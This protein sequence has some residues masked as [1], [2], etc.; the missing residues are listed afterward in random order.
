MNKS[1]KDLLV[2]QFADAVV[3]HAK[4]YVPQAFAGDIEAAKYLA[5]SLN[6]HERGAAAVLMWQLKVKR[7]AFQAF[8]DSVWL[9]DHA[10]VISA[11]ATRRRLTSMFK[12]ADFPLPDFP[13]LLQVWRGTVGI[14]PEEASKGYSWTCN[15]DVA[16]WFATRY[17]AN[18]SQ[19]ITATIRREE[20]VYFS[21]ERQEQEVVLAKEPHFFCVDGDADNWL[22]TRNRW[23]S[24]STKG[25]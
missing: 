21:N 20:I 22:A 9:H 24:E 8:F 4:K 2:L 15:R 1:Y 7:S 5:V 14:K 19:V 12:Y 18:E 17:D 16:C 25:S 3:Q 6:N 11:A 10:H 13:E 23:L